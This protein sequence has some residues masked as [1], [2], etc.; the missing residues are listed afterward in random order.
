[1]TTRNLGAALAA[2][3]VGVLAGL[4]TAVAC[5]ADGAPGAA[6][7]AAFAGSKARVFVLA[8]AEKGA[9]VKTDAALDELASGFAGI[10]VGVVG[11]A[12]RD[13]VVAIDDSTGE[14]ATRL[15]ASAGE[16]VVTDAAGGVVAKFAMGTPASVI[17]ARIEQSRRA[18]TDQYNIPG[19]SSL[20]IEGYD[21]VS[22]FEASSPLKG[23]AKITSR[24]R[25]VVYRFASAANRAK[26][27]TDPERYAP[28]YGGWC[29]TAMARGE[30]VEIDPTNYKVSNGRLFL[31]YKGFLG[32]ARND[33]ENDE[34]RLERD[35][36]AAWAKIVK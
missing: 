19:K 32:N 16:I 15:G 27:N 25:G 11:G 22:Y 36:D 28:T 3:I 1:M 12:G 17:G 5:V 26:F 6:L 21:P 31:F 14:L 18:P 24:Y 9:E 8:I 30:K 4:Q 20:A 10:G 35:A 7:S 23:D 29:A 13:G 34:K 2:L 33:W